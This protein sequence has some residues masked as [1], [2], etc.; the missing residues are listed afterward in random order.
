ML[1][2]TLA[3]LTFVILLP[4]LPAFVLYK[5]LPSKA[6]V[7][8]PFKGL[9]IRLQGAFGGY[10]VLV[11]IAVG[12]VADQMP[13]PDTF[14]KYEEYELLGSLELEGASAEELDR[15]LVRLILHP[16]IERIEGPIGSNHFEWVA[17]LPAKRNYDGTL[18]WPFQTIMIEYPGYFAEQIGIHSGEVQSDAPRLMFGN[19]TLKPRRASPQLRRE[20]ELNNAS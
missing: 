2:Q 12:I 10:I 18:V 19:I 9:D 5:T 14:P 20:V 16:R 4:L 6:S 15:R 11:M 3:I 17:R 8:G 1:L 13:D 7:K